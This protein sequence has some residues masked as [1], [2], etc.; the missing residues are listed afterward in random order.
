MN[1]GADSVKLGAAGACE[2]GCLTEMLGDFEGVIPGGGEPG[3][4]LSTKLRSPAFEG[5]LVREISSSKG[6]FVGGWDSDFLALAACAAMLL[7]FAFL[8]AT[9]PR[10][11]L[12]G[13][14]AEGFSLSHI[15]L[16]KYP[17]VV[18]KL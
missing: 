14:S 10:A 8:L 1:D 16:S 12:A 11:F 5:V 18:N 7:A 3:G 13:F 9:P 6:G 15:S 17:V 2:G 4:P